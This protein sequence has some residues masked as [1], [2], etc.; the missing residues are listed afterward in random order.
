MT[1]IGNLEPTLSFL[2]QSKVLLIEGV[3]GVGKTSFRKYLQ[4]ELAVHGKHT[5]V[6]AEEELLFSWKHVAI[7]GIEELRFSFYEKLLAEVEQELE[8]HDD[9]T[10]VL[11]R[12]HVSAKVISWYWDARL[13][14]HYVQISKRLAEISAHLCILTLTDEQFAVRHGHPDRGAQWADYLEKKKVQFGVT[15]L[16][17]RVREEQVLFIEIA[18][19]SAIPHTII[20]AFSFPLI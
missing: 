20:P 1:P 6:F 5:F 4:R 12:F 13:E 3:S 9:I 16:N 19:A 15:D 10:F 2:S 11:E 17:A 18:K 7:S 14:E 8:K